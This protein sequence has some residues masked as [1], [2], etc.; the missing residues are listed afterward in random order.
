MCR[1]V[2]LS[3]V[4]HSDETLYTPHK[5]LIPTGLMPDTVPGCYSNAADC[6]LCAVLHIRD[7]FYNWQRVR[8]NLKAKGTEEHRAQL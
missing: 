7:C 3:G 5:A 6:L 4:Q 2:A 1:V 8:L